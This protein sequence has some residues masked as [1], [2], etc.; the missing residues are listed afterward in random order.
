MPS[1]NNF[2]PTRQQV[3]SPEQLQRFLTGLAEMV[4]RQDAQQSQQS[5]QSQQQSAQGVEVTSAADD[6][7][8][9]WE[10]QRANILN[11]VTTG[12]AALV[13]LGVDQIATRLSNLA[14]TSV[15]AV[16]DDLTKGYGVGSIW[17]NT[18]TNNVY[19][20]ANVSAGA[21]VWRLLN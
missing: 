8:R 12:P 20:A 18:T 13:Q 9:Q 21:A 11:G 1:A 16:T 5:Q 7:E 14:A 17:I 3:E 10:L 6:I 19:L 2:Y 15:P 4:Y